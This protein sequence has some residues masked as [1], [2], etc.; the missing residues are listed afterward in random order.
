MGEGL[1]PEI[2]KKVA[3]ILRK[4]SDEKNQSYNHQIKKC[5]SEKS[6][7]KAGNTRLDEYC[8]IIPYSIDVLSDEFYKGHYL[9]NVDLKN[10]LNAIFICMSDESLT[11]GTGL[12]LNQRLQDYNIPIIIR[13]V[14]NKGL[15]HF[16]SQICVENAEEYKNLHPFPLVSC[17]CCIESLVGITELIARSIHR[18]YILMCVPGG[19]FAG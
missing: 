19:R 9:D 8:E 3:T 18:N 16:F 7:L 10:P 12:Y 15:A 13:T 6:I 5:R 4:E 17:S 14:Y 1:I 2:C 11:F